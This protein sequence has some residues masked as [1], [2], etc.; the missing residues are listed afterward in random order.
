MEGLTAQHCL[1]IAAA[2]IAIIGACAT[3]ISSAN[4]KAES[5]SI[6]IRNSCQEFREQESEQKNG[7]RCRQL[8]RQLDLFTERFQGA[9]RAQGLLFSTIAIFIMS[10][11]IFIGLG[12]YLTASNMSVHQMQLVSR[13]YL[14]AIGGCVVLGT[15]SMLIAIFFLFREIGKASETLRIEMSDCRLSGTL[16]PSTANTSALPQVS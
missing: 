9:Q 8:Q 2:F 5:L 7:T 15:V 10:L 6:R 16:Q 12:L 13:P 1:A 11:A 4:S 3:L 14:I